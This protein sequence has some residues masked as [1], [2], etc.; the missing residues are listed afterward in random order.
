MYVQFVHRSEEV[1]D[2]VNFGDFQQRDFRK[3][4]VITLRFLNLVLDLAV[5]GSEPKLSKLSLS[6][7]IYLDLRC[8]MFSYFEFFVEDFPR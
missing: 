7:A 3:S 1:A 2:F 8:L 6:T 5:S 4:R